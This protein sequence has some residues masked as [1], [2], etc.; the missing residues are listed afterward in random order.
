MAEEYSTVELILSWL[1]SD[2]DDDDAKNTI[3]GSN[4]GDVFTASG[5][6]IPSKESVSLVFTT[7]FDSDNDEYGDIVSHGW[8]LER[9]I[10][11][12]YEYSGVN[13]H[14]NILLQDGFLNIDD[15]LIHW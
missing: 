5:I 9:N 14:G 1:W 6:A 7:I 3:N 12:I 4:I 15:W 13:T 8:F 11:D 10:G 2:L